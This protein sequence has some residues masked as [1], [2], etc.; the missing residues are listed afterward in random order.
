MIGQKFLTTFTEKSSG[1]LNWVLRFC[2]LI[3]ESW[4]SS[5]YFSVIVE[6]YAFRSV[7]KI[8]MYKSKQWYKLRRTLYAVPKIQS[9][10]FLCG[11]PYLLQSSLFILLSGAD[12]VI[13]ERLKAGQEELKIDTQDHL[14]VRIV[15][16]Y[17]LDNSWGLKFFYS[18]SKEGIYISIF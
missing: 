18:P 1:V 17:F 2:F 14:D 8:I 5:E 11:F 9:A 15:I 7:C 16:F 12:V 3:I 10:V 4:N 13:F 6:R